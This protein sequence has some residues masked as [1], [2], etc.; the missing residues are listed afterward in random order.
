MVLFVVL[1]V[2]VLTKNIILKFAV[3][4]GV[5]A[6]TGLQLEIGEFDLGIK[7]T[8]I[9]IKDLN[10][11]N[12]E[13]YALED[14]VMFNSHDVFVN[15]NLQAI[16]KGK[17]HLEEIRLDLNE[18]MIVRDVQGE[19]NFNVLMPAKK[20]TTSDKPD[21]TEVPEE[22]GEAKAVDFQIDRLLVRIG[23]IVYKDYS[24][25]GEPMI[26]EYQ[27]NFYETFENISN[28][29]DVF[30][31]VIQKVLAKTALAKFA[32][33]DIN[34]LDDSGAIQNTID[35]FKDKIKLPFGGK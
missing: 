6:A 22:K 11:L 5:A 30:A 31:V 12:P 34:S 16:L 8:H 20:E 19:F 26:K 25:E 13:G 3:E 17:I 24:V 33:F 35:T 28:V 27:V 4:K 32:D 23:K 10:L 7:D 14:R 21:P 1:V 18:L 2:L 15:Y 29:Q 9:G